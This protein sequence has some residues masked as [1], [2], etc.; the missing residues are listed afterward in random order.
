M[1]RHS[2]GALFCLWV[3]IFELKIVGES[4]TSPEATR[5]G[6]GRA[7]HILHVD[8]LSAQ[9]FQKLATHRVQHGADPL[10]AGGGPGDRHLALP[11]RIEIILERL[12]RFCGWNQ[13]GVVTQ[14]DIDLA[15]GPC[16][17]AAFAL[18]FCVIIVGAELRREMV[19]QQAAS[20]QERLRIRGWFRRHRRGTCRLRVLR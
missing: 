19:L 12:W 8:F 9:F 17:H 18:H 10:G 13:F 14:A 16:E 4:G 11:F 7:G 1:G 20:H 5:P 15:I 2:T 3:K 6:Q